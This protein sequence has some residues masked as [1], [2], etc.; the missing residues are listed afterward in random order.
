MKTTDDYFIFFFHIKGG[1]LFYK[2]DM[3]T[4][5]INIMLHKIKV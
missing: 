5:K 1:Y 3:N 4:V 2:R